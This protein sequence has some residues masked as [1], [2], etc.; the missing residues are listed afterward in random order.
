MPGIFLTLRGP[1][2]GMLRVASLALLALQG[3]VV[4]SPLVEPRG[5]GRLGA[6]AEQDGA[7]H[8]NLHNEATC[9][10]CSARAQTSMPGQ[11]TPDIECL[12]AQV[13]AAL[14][15]YAAPTREDAHGTLSRAPPPVS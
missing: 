8:L 2:R 12:R 7:R 10:L 4:A 15:T 3:A 6:H 13:V 1:R 14:E 11:V 9:A 5:E